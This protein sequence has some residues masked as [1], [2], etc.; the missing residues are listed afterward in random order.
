MILHQYSPSVI[1]IVYKIYYYLNSPDFNSIYEESWLQ[2]ST[3][4]VLVMNSS[5]KSGVLD[6]IS[7]LRIA[8]KSSAIY[9]N[10]KT[11]I[12]LV[13]KTDTHWCKDFNQVDKTLENSVSDDELVHLN[14]YQL[15]IF[16][17]RHYLSHYKFNILFECFRICISS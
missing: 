1:L 13:K 7:F 15:K 2:G 4:C 3:L 11:Y 9:N 5:C 16:I 8:D 10:N 17:W 14:F 12:L 6:K